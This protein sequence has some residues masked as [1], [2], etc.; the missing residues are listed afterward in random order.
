MGV[1]YVIFGQSSGFIYILKKRY[2]HLVKSTII[3]SIILNYTII[4]VIRYHNFTF[5]KH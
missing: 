4:C 2:Y 3:I 1:T 5:I